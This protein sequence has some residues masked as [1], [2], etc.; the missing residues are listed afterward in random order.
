MH[1]AEIKITHLRYGDR[2]VAAVLAEAIEDFL[3]EPVQLRAFD[4]ELADWRSH[5]DLSPHV[6]V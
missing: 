1:C 2:V 3:R 6:W 4:L 5:W